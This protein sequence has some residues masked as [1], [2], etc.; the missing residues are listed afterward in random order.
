MVTG[1]IDGALLCLISGLRAKY[2]G[3]AVNLSG[4][5]KILLSDNLSNV[6]DLAEIDV[7]GIDSLEGDTVVVSPNIFAY[8][9]SQLL[10]FFFFSREY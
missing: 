9:I 7:G 3:E 8:T 1:T 6:A 5:G 10:S 4:C 2:G